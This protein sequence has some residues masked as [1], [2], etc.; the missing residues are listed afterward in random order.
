[1]NTFVYERIEIIEGIFI[2]STYYGK[3]EFDLEEIL[4]ERSHLDPL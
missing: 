3:H 1:M 4:K 2:L